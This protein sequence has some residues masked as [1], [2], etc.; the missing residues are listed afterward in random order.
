MTSKLRDGLHRLW[1]IPEVRRSGLLI[2]RSVR[3]YFDDHCPQMAAA[4]AYHVVFS[5]FPLAIA[6]VG[7]LGLLTG[8][9]QAR[10]TVT[11]AIMKVIPLDDQGRAQLYDLLVSIGGRAG[12]LGLFGLLGVLWSATGMMAAIRTSLNVAWDTDEGRPFLRGKLVDVVLVV[13]TTLLLASAFGVTLLTSFAQR[14]TQHLPAVLAPLAGP[15]VQGLTVVLALLVVTL[16]FLGLMRFVPA[17]PNKTSDLWWGAATAGV[18][19]EILLY[20]FSFY[21]SHFGNYNK[22]YGPLGT[23]VAFMF[24]LYLAASVFLLGAEVASEYPRLP[25]RKSKRQP[26]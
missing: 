16:T 8:T 4:I 9:D 14:G 7:V 19:F 11:S 1:T 24:F 2:S 23:V 10:E 17:R 18:G 13:S 12:A 25:E 22:V 6:G 3:E 5:L 21:I 15:L 20:A 26:S